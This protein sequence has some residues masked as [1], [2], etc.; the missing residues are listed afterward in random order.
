MQTLLQ[1]SLQASPPQQNSTPSQER[2]V[3]LYSSG[4]LDFSDNK[5]MRETLESSFSNMAQERDLN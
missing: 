2:P 3:I 5:I 4:G 1:T